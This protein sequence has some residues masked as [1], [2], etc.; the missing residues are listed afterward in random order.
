M[1]ADISRELYDRACKALTWYEHPEE[2]P[3][4][5]QSIP[6]FLY[7]ALVEIVNSIEQ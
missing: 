4:E 2:C 6:G 7:D 3:L 1:I 5:Q